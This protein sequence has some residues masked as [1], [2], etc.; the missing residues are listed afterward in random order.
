MPCR[1]GSNPHVLVAVQLAG[2][3]T[4]VERVRDPRRRSTRRAVP[5]AVGRNR[6]DVAHHVPSAER[7]DAARLDR[8][9]DEAWANLSGVRAAPSGTILR[10]FDRDGHGPLARSAI[11]RGTDGAR[12]TAYRPVRDRCTHRS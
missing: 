12:T 9:I 1:A 11:Y 4:P 8:S 2:G 7:L 3:R 10:R 5:T 6:R